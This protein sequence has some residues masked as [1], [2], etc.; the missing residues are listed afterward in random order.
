MPTD[1]AELDA[2]AW[3]EQFPAAITICDRQGTA[4]LLNRAAREH[5][6]PAGKPDLKGSNLLDC[7]PGASRQAMADLLEHPHQKMCTIERDGTPVLIFMAPWQAGG[8]Q[9]VFEMQLELPAGVV[10]APKKKITTRK[11]PE[12]AACLGQTLTAEIDR[13]LGSPLPGSRG[14]Y[15]LNCG[16]VPEIAGPDGQPLEAYVPGVFEPL[17]R[18]TGRAIA[19]IHRPHGAGDA[20]VLAPGDRKYTEEQIRALTEFAEGG[21]TSEIF[22]EV[23]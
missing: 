4:L 14:L 10:H 16:C 15:P 21:F 5:Y 8:N 18:F 13:P 3:L 20:L 17:E 7:H 19:L 9:G 22:C 2:S 11:A 23:V 1:I 6:Q 12:A